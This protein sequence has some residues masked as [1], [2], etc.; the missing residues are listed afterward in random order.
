M[1]VVGVDVGSTA[2]KAGVIDTGG[3]VQTLEAVEYTSFSSRPGWLEQDP[4]ELWRAVC[5]AVTAAVRPLGLRRAGIRALA[6]SVQRGTVVPVD[7][8]GRAI[9]RAISWQ[10][11]RA[12]AE[13]VWLSERLGERFERI[14]GLYPSTYWTVA[15]LAWLAREEP[16]VWRAAHQFLFVHGYLARRLGADVAAE[17][18]TNAS[19]SGLLDLGTR[20]WSDEILDLLGLPACRLGALQRPGSVIGE[21]SRV[22]AGSL[23]L[24][25]D[26]LLVCGAGDQQAVALG[27][28]T[29]G[30]GSI[31]ISIG[32]AGVVV[33]C[34]RSRPASAE[35]G[36]ACLVHPVEPLVQIEAMLGSAGS[37]LR[38][39]ASLTKSATGFRYGEAVERGLYQQID[40]EAASVPPGSEG[41]T[42]IPYFGAR[43]A[44][45]GS[46]GGVIAGLSLSHGRASLARAIMEGAA[47]EVR[48]LLGAMARYGIVPRNLVICGGGAQSELW[49]QIVADVQGQPVTALRCPQAGVVGAGILAATGLGLYPSLHEAARQMLQL[50]TTFEPGPHRATYDGLFREYQRMVATLGPAPEDLRSP[51]R[52]ERDVER[53]GPRPAGPIIPR[54]G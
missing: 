35:P 44:G 26:V 15:K 2:V 37:V 38:W 36:I 14:T 7:R 12:G 45:T 6:L 54:A 4:D 1:L 23:G 9:Y 52:W 30:P 21:I 25:A 40:A 28:G 51:A 29:V 17:D 48:R 43:H 11:L 8:A 16:T 33:S 24:P 31:A 47:F 19:F 10:D 39:L 13:C 46:Y 34:L 32:T 22:A 42:V 41:V 18:P 3:E 50:G 27:A 49:G 5:A 53:H 20:R